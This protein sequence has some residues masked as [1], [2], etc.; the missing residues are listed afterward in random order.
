MLQKNTNNFFYDNSHLIPKISNQFLE[1][2]HQAHQSSSSNFLGD[3]SPMIEKL[4]FIYLISKWTGVYDG[5]SLAHWVH[6]SNDAP[7]LDWN[8]NDKPLGN[9]KQDSLWNDWIS[10]YCAVIQRRSQQLTSN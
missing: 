6:Y 4:Q 1:A 2:L 5:W 10:Q 9:M 8:I 3:Y 7:D